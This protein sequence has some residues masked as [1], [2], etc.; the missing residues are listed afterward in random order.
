MT[1]TILPGACIVFATASLAVLGQGQTPRPTFRTDI[2][3]V[4]IDVSVIDAKHQPIRGLRASDFT[5]LEDGKP[6]PIRVFEAVDLPPI[7]PQAGAAGAADSAARVTTNQ[8]GNEDGRL[9]FILMDKT[10]PTGQPVIAAR[11]AAAAAINALGPSDLAAIVTTSGHVPQTL[12]SDRTRLLRALDRKDWSTQPSPEQEEI[13]GKYDPFSDARCLCGLCVLETVTNLAEIARDAPRRRKLLLF[14]GSSIV[15]QAGP[16]DPSADVGCE[17][18]VR[19]AREKMVEALARAHLT[20]NSIDPSGLASTF[21]QGSGNGKPGQDAPAVRRQKQLNDTIQRLQDQGS[22]DVLPGL[23][24]GRTFTN[25]NAPETAVPAIFQE[26]SAYYLIGFE[27]YASGSETRRRIDVK[28]ARAGARVATIKATPPAHEGASA[29]PPL[30]RALAGLLPEARVPL[31]MTLASFASP[32]AS[33]AYVIVTLNASAFGV[34]PQRAVD[35]VVLVHDQRG[36]RVA[37]V[38]EGAAIVR[39]PGTLQTHVMLPPGDYELRA[40]VQTRDT[41]AT[42]SVFSQL[43]VPGF[44]DSPL[45]MSDL[46]VGTQA[47]PNPPPDEA[48][49]DLPVIASTAR[50]FHRG[51]AA[52]I[53][54]HVYEGT[55]KN[56]AIDPVTIRTVVTDAS[57]RTARDERVTMGADTFVGRHV[58]LRI[59][60]PTATPAGR[61]AMRI[62]AS[63]GA[64]VVA[65]T[66]AYAIQ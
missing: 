42:S 19:D 27:P 63:R 13:V 14:I 20:V 32:D 53:F 17:N 66:V 62:E 55:Q 43:T 15:V 38:R 50:A 30:D 2:G 1:R 52:W 21:Y 61:Y 16:R 28:V 41:G 25:T 37:T 22:L 33:K 39:P 51:D 49:P 40:A 18:R 34:E 36:R 58:G 44:G 29:R 4:Q 64:R 9:V 6:R 54:A 57:G 45:S 23:T 3:L 10:I 8:A 12:T 35:V 24:G 47:N 5:V 7:A 59:R 65:R 56:D 11:H 60:V 31:E 26:S 46:V 48:A